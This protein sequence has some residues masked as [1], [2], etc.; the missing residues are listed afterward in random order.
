MSKYSHNGGLYRKLESPVTESVRHT[1]GLYRKT[2]VAIVE[3]KEQ[4]VEDVITTV[5]ANNA[6]STSKKPLHG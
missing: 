6:A 5:E 4:S 2:K 1:E 3:V